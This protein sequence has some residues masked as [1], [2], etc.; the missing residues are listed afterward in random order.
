M[1]SA[2]VIADSVNPAGQRITTFE[3]VF[4]RWILAEVN[5]HRMLS[6]NSAS[7]RA[8][9]T[10]KLLWSVLRDPATPVKWG[11][12]QSGMQAHS[13]LLGFRKWLA[14]RLFFMARY[15]AVLFAWLL[16]KIGLHK[17]LTNRI[18]E[19]WMWHTAIITATTF[20]NLFKLR[21]HPDAQPEFQ[22]LANEMQFRY[23]VSVPR[24]IPWLGWHLPYVDGIA[25]GGPIH[26]TNDPMLEIPKVSAACCARVS[27]VR[28]SDRRA[29]EEDMKLA[30]RLIKS[31]HWSPF[32]HVAQAMVGEGQSGNFT[33][34]WKQLRKFYAGEDGI[35]K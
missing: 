34:G 4:P 27:Y 2:K 20:D 11:R 28:Q 1:I 7:S 5:T 17:Q 32:E 26:G 29:V 31:G 9:P 15:P 30:G 10:K 16:S 23:R 12:N 22:E 25:M 6:R 21:A 13:D 3:C 18:V 8:I 24:Q 19:P 33:G 14:K 35:K